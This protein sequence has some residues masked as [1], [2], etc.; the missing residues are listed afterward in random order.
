MTKWNTLHDAC[1]HALYHWHITT[2]PPYRKHIPLTFDAQHI[3]AHFAQATT[4]PNTCHSSKRHTILHSCQPTAHHSK[5]FSLSNKS[6]KRSFLTI[7][8][9]CWRWDLGAFGKGDEWVCISAAVTTAAFSKT[10]DQEATMSFSPVFHDVFLR[11]SK[12]VQINAWHDAPLHYRLQR[13]FAFTLQTYINYKQW[14][15]LMIIPLVASQCLTV[16]LFWKHTLILRFNQFRGPHRNSSLARHWAKLA[17]TYCFG[18][19]CNIP[20]HSAQ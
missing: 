5:F 11:V 14:F 8:S 1:K 7:S 6:S 10:W 13:C 19:R 9:N 3:A 15:T 2:R 20:P 12:Y 17:L 16:I 18:Q 4:R